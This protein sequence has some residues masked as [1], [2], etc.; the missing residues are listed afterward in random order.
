MNNKLQFPTTEIDFVG[1]VGLTGQDHDNYADPGTLP[2]YDWMR[3]V[4]L[5]LLANQ[6]S[7]EEPTQY[8][9]GTLHYDLNTFFYKC[10][11]DGN[12]EDISKCIK[13]IG[14][15]LY[16]WSQDIEEKR[17]RFQLAGTFSG[18]AY[19]DSNVINIPQNLQEISVAPNKPYL[20]KNGKIIDPA[21]TQF[22]S[23]CPVAIELSGAAILENEDTFTVFIRN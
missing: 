4:V 6:A 3:M 9:P 8:R 11:K 2:R 5:G 1:D 17:A 19:D 14:E 23:G 18:V 21:L 20:F 7:G 15:S 16:A 13:T 12:F 22:N 10:M